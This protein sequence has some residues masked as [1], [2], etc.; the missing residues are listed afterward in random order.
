MNQAIA[1][2]IRRFHKDG[3]SRRDLCLQFG[4]TKRVLYLVLDNQKFPQDGYE[5]RATPKQVL[6][7]F[8][9]AKLLKLWDDGYSMKELQKVVDEETGVFINLGTLRWNLEDY[10]L[11]HAIANQKALS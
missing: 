11:R 6:V 7:K 9:L 3:K 10:E 4:I 8:G 1:N 2:R 5:K